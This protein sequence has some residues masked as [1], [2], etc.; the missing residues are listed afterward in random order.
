MLARENNGE[1]D[2][3]TQRS[4]TGVV[5]QAAALYPS[6]ARTAL[7][8]AV[9]RSETFRAPMPLHPS[10]LRRLVRAKIGFNALGAHEF[11]RCYGTEDS[12][13][14]LQRSLRRMS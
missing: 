12:A 3:S 6:R 2:L 9:T 4:T 8:N 10:Q 7:T 11:K 13:H 1:Q 14:R 5:V